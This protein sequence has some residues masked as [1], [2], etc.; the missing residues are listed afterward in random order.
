MAMRPLILLLLNLQSYVMLPYAVGIANCGEDKRFQVM[1]GGNHYKL[2]L[3][4]SR[5]NCTDSRNFIKLDR[6]NLCDV[7]DTIPGRKSRTI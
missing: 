3:C 6:S 7:C 2:Q 1:R 5:G 4:I